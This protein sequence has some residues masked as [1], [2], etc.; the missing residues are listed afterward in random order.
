[1]LKIFKEHTSNTCILDDFEFYED[2]Q[3]TMLDKR[4][5]QHF[6]K[7]ASCFF[8]VQLVETACELIIH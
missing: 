6:Q 8:C 7:Q 4:A 1:M 5:N 2:C 3:N